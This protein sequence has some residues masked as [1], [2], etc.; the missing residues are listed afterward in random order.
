MTVRTLRYRAAGADVNGQG[1]GG[2]NPDS[3]ERHAGLVQTTWYAAPALVPH[4][5]ADAD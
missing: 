4:C 5:G 2:V 3:P 1:E